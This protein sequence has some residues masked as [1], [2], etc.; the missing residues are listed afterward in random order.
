MTK[1]V[2]TKWTGEWCEGWSDYE[3]HP[4][5]H[6]LILVDVK[7]LTVQRHP[8]DVRHRNPNL[9]GKDKPED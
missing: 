5:T 6:D 2:W 8:D 1:P 7:G 9:N 3:E 4:L